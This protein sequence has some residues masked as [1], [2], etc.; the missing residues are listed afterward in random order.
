MKKGW[1]FAVIV[2]ITRVIVAQDYQISFAILGDDETALDSVEV[3]YIEQNHKITFSGDDILHLFASKTG[4]SGLNVYRPLEIYPNPF[5]EKAIIMFQND[6]EGIIRVTL[7]NMVGKTLV[8]KSLMQSAG[9][10]IFEVSGLPTGA[11]L[12]RIDTETSVFSEMIF[13]NSTTEDH[14]NINIK[15]SLTNDATPKTSFKS[16]KGSEGI[17]D[18]QYHTGDTLSITGYRGTLNSEIKIVP[19]SSTTIRFNFSTNPEDIKRTAVITVEGGIMELSDE[20]GNRITLNFPPG[21]VLDS[22][23]VSLTLWGEYINLPIEKRHLRTFEISPSDMKLYKPLEISIEYSSAI[24]E[25]QQTALF[26]MHSESF[27]TP[28]GD[29]TY[30]DDKRMMTATTYIPGNFA[31]GKMTLEQ[32]NSQFD[33]LISYLGISWESTMKSTLEGSRPMFDGDLHKAIWDEWRANA[34]GLLKLMDLRLG[35]GHY[36]ELEEG[37]PTFEEEIELL[38]NNVV[39]KGVQEVLDLGFP[40]N[41][42]DRDYTLTIAS[43]LQDMMLLGCDII[44]KCEGCEHNPEYDRLY[45]RYE[46]TLVDCKSYL[47]I[48][49]EI[50]IGNGAMIVS[51]IGVVPLT[52]TTSNNDK[53]TV[54]GEGTLKVSGS[55]NDDP[56]STTIEGVTAVDVYG[57]RDAAYTYVL[58]VETY[59]DAMKTEVCPHNIVIKTPMISSGSREMIFSRA[60]DYT[61]NIEEPIEGGTFKMDVTLFSPYAS[62]PINK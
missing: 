25:I 49:S 19:V 11:Y 10:T 58:T 53:G 1:I 5:S 62:I 32:V 30:S 12:I 42:C 55:A 24:D 18:M 48:F 2:L 14:P 61:V 54:T 56:C 59:Q 52:L 7:I 40:E 13:S 60:N 3:R 39:N 38:C 16:L 23:T 20:S 57:T 21:A 4:I 27:I 31:E 29:L 43:M 9:K 8:R 37:E 34:L 44:P 22:T 46:E 28:T 36:D 26:Y 15:G 45:E 41:P 33:Q 47:S 35:N 17:V 51:T 50:N 6:H